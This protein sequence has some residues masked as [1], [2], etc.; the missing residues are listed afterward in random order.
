MD[1]IPPP[2]SLVGDADLNEAFRRCWLPVAYSDDVSDTPVAAQLLGERLVV[3]RLGGRVRAFPETC[4]HR[5]TA[6]T[7]GRIDGDCLTC[8]YHGWSYDADGQCVNIPS[9]P[10]SP[11]PPKARLRA[12]ETAEA[13]GIVWV[14]LDGNPILPL[15]ECPELE[16]PRFR[17]IKAPVYEWGCSA[18]RR[19]ENYIDFAHFAWVHD[20]LLGSERAPEVAPHSV[21]RRGNVLFVDYTF[22]DSHVDELRRIYGD[23]GMLVPRSVYHLNMPLT[24]HMNGHQ[25]DGGHYV[26]FLAAAPVTDTRVRC[27]WFILRDFGHDAPDDFFIA[28]ESAILAQDQPIVESQRP[29]EIPIDVTAELHIRGSDRVSFEYRSWLG[30]I[31][32]AVNP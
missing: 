2:E 11:I 3:V 10:G 21:E 31:A 13:A 6:L 17:A 14:C 20:G 22:P 25:L 12:F 5:G 16:D 15:P 4:I 32:G 26:L 23:L 27:F 18:P 24:V 1:V 7:L 19:V 8:A 9:R 30:E 28:T 29:E